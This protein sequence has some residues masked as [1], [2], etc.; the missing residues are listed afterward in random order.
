MKKIILILLL[1]LISSPAIAEEVQETVEA[2]TVT[3]IHEP[4]DQKPENHN[5]YSVVDQNGVIQ[6]NVVCA[7]SVCGDNGQ[8]S[9]SMPQDTPWAGMKLVKQRSGNVGGYWGT[10]D[11]NNQTFTVDRSCSTC[12]VFSDMQKPGTIKDGIVTDPIIIP[13]LDTYMLNNPELTID[14]AADLLKEL[15]QSQ[16]YSLNAIK[17]SFI[18]KGKG[19]IVTKKT[20]YKTIKLTPNLKDFKK[21]SKTK[22][23]CKIKNNSVLIL[24]S[25]TCKIDIY[26]DGKKERVN[27]KVKK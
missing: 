17:S 18:V 6:N 8:W 14:E 7:D 10:Y 15:L 11:S 13:G 24:K 25:G 1:S 19:V 27:T 9:G 2:P 5:I 26:K 4:E 3:V 23:I 22:N 20:K 12:E 16:S 21:I